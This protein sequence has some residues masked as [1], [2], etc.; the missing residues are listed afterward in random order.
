MCTLSIISQEQSIIITMNRD[1]QRDRHEDGALHSANGQCFPIDAKSG[2]TWIGTNEHGLTLALLN[3][4]QGEHVAGEA[5][6][7]GELIPSFLPCSTVNAVEEKLRMLTL[8]HFNPFDCI[9]VDE[10]GITHAIWDGRAL[11]F[12]RHR[13]D[14]PFFITSSSER[15]TE[16]IAHRKSLFSEFVADESEAM[17]AEHIVHNLHLKRGHDN[18]E[19]SILMHREHTHTKSITQIV[20][21]Q[22]NVELRYWTEAALAKASEHFQSYAITHA[23]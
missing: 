8:N 14:K 9:G 20:M 22:K 12:E 11:N 7:R 21:A 2:G 3:R 23:L 1:E 18:D 10:S 19:S 15:T 13:V 4:Y 6:S 17:T 5:Q 16:I